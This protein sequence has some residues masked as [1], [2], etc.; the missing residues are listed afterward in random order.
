MFAGIDG[1]VFQAFAFRRHLD[2]LRIE[3][4][5][6]VDQGFAISETEVDLTREGP[7]KTVD[8]FS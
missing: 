4:G 8:Y 6:D 5:D 3:A 2:P 7:L 1:S